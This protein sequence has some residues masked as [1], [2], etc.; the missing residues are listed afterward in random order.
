[1]RLQDKT[2]IVTGGAHGIGKAIASRFAREGAQVFVIDVDSA[3]GKKLAAQIGA[4]F[5]KCNVADPVEV[6][7]AVKQAARTGRI[8][9]LCNNAAFIAS[10]WHNALEAEDREWQ[11]CV[12]VSLI[13]SRH[14]IRATL[15]FMRKGG[16]SIINISSIQGLVGGRDSVAYTTVK[17]ALIGLTRSVARDFGADNIRCNAL[18]PGAVT[19]RISPKPGSELHQ[20]QVKNTFLGRVGRPEEIAAAALFLA[21]DESSYITGAVLAVDGGWTAM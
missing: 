3:A 15:P 20:R 19:T 4:T 6:N 18:C 8:D 11:R 1:M 12:D 2:A 14:F 10:R 16:G 5:V 7:R 17:H 9:V 21:S 13:G